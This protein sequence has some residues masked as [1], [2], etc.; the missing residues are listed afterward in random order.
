MLC[1]VLFLFFLVA[2]VYFKQINVLVIKLK[3]S[4]KQND[5][6]FGIIFLPF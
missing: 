5:Y 2:F 1:F 3:F 6:G 4:L